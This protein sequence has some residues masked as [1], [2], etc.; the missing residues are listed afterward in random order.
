MWH[1]NSPKL[2]VY[3]LSL[4]CRPMPPHAPVIVDISKKT[5]KQWLRDIFS[6]TRECHFKSVMMMIM[7]TLSRNSLVYSLLLP[8]HLPFYSTKCSFSGHQYYYYYNL[9]S[10]QY[11]LLYQMLKLCCEST[12]NKLKAVVVLD[13]V[14]K[15][16]LSL[17]MGKFRVWCTWSSGF[18]CRPKRLLHRTAIDHV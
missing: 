18:T 9:H 7:M 6:N 13:A 1:D 3:Q 11:Y 10:W 4:I 8:Y 5:N 17:D 12:N 16:T 14:Y 2:C 15:K